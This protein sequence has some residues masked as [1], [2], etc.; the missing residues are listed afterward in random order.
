MAK[1]PTVQDF[2]K[3]F[4]D[5]NACLDYLMKLRH[6]EVIDC[7]KCNKEGRTMV[8]FLDPKGPRARRHLGAVAIRSHRCAYPLGI[9]KSY[10]GP[11]SW[12]AVHLQRSYPAGRARAY[13]F[14]PRTR[15][16]PSGEP[17]VV[18]VDFITYLPPNVR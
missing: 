9:E 7:P 14:E 13:R 5:D 8:R 6:G 4:P 17:A 16:L 12:F 15:S 10:H 3:Q 18:A 2:F 11:S 1:A